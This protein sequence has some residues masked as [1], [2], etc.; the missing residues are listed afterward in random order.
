M[1]TFLLP[2]QNAVSKQE[3]ATVGGMIQLSRNIGGAAGI[4]LLTSVLA[5]TSTWGEATFQYG[6]LFSV[7]FLFSLLGFIIGSQFEGAAIKGNK[8][9]GI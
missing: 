4:P 5:L 3:Q 8:D 9:K 6:I 1:P 2:A 7:L